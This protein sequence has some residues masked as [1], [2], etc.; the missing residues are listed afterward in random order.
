MSKEFK[1]TKKHIEKKYKDQIILLN[2]IIKIK[3]APSSIHGVGVFAMQDIKKGEKLYTDMIPH[4]FDLP[5]SKFSKL[6]KAIVDILLGHFPLIIEGSHFLYPVTK[7][8][9][10]LNHS[11]TPNYDAVNDVA[12]TDIKKDEEITED[13]RLIA[14]YDKIFKWLVDKK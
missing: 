8:S 10:Y 9:A 12:L 11:Y 14:N 7:F 5:F 6:K 13:Y 4:Q 2:D 3:I 1:V